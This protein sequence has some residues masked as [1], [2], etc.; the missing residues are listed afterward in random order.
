[1]PDGPIGGEE[2]GPLMTSMLAWEE[3]SLH[4]G[5]FH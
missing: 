1:M 4:E 2:M 5:A 3:S